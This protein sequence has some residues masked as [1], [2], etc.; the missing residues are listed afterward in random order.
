[1]AVLDEPV[2][3]DAD[4]VLLLEAAPAVDLRRASHRA[5]LRSDDPVVKGP[6]VGRIVA[7]A[8]HNVM[9]D[10]AQAGGDGPHLR[11]DD[12]LGDLRRGE[13]FVD[14][15]PGEVD[16]G[17]VIEGHDDL[18]QPE[19]RHGANRIE[20]RQAADNLFDGEG[21]LLLDLLGSQGR[22]TGIDLH[23]DGGGVGKGVEVEVA[24]G[25][26]T[27]HGKGQR[28][29]ENQ[30]AVPQREVDDPVQHGTCPPGE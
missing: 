3:V 22:R 12:T 11:A 5:Q 17:A 9:E 1:Q 26:D 18:G 24:H 21:D 25:E 15:L 23:L 2:G 4:Q 6:Q 29:P 28:Y 8:G 13:P 27:A 14:E 10:F 7:L 16:V 19:L 30:E 20:V